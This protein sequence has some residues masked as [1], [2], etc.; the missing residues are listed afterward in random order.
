MTLEGGIVEAGWGRSTTI[1]L[2][3]GGAIGLYEPRHPVPAGRRSG[4]PRMV[5]D[6]V[7]AAAAFLREVFDAG[8]S[9]FEG[10]P[11]EVTI[12][13]AT[14]LVGQAGEREAFPAFLY[15]TVDDP[16]AVYRRALA[17]GT[18]SIEE[19]F[20]TSYGARRAMVGDPLGSVFQIAGSE[21]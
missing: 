4:V 5:V 13:D 15:V 7:A 9:G 11:A 6:D 21:H 2:P 20:D 16:D 18:S 19:P 10:A 12:G 8:V 1:R 3:G 17:A 14:I